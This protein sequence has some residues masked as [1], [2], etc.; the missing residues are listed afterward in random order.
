MG[1]FRHVRALLNLYS[2]CPDEAKQIDRL[3]S[4]MALKTGIMEG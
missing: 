3:I 1:V 2:K 4:L